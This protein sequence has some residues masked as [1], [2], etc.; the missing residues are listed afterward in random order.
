MYTHLPEHFLCSKYMAHE[1]VYFSEFSVVFP[2]HLVYLRSVSSEYSPTHPAPSAWVLADNIHCLV[3]KDAQGC[4]LC[5]CTCEN[6]EEHDAVRRK[7]KRVLCW[8]LCKKRLSPV[9][10]LVVTQV[11]LMVTN[12]SVMVTVKFDRSLNNHMWHWW[13]WNPA[14]AINSH[15]WYT[16]DR[17]GTEKGHWT[18]LA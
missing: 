10:Y 12:I 13:C 1:E 3:Y 4:L 16:F 5:W 7:N 18:Q 17:D 15:G 6:T 11:V 2:G 14:S 9:C 8:T